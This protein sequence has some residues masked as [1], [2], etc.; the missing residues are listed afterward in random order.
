MRISSTPPPPRGRS[1]D[2]HYTAR[3]LVYPRTQQSNPLI[4]RFSAWLHQQLEAAA[5]V[6]VC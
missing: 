2:L 6:D 1:V 3:F 4:A 5:W